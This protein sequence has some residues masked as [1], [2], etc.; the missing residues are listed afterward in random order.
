MI[1]NVCTKNDSYIELW[2]NE[3]MEGMIFAMLTQYLEKW[4]FCF[5]KMDA[6]FSSAA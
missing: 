4:F 2:I 5:Y 1:M 6:R 3:K